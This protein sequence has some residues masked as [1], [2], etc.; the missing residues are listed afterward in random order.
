M[1]T[2]S[3]TLRQII[4]NAYAL[5]SEQSESSFS[6]KASPEKWSKKEIL[7]HLIDS[8]Y[9]NHQRFL[10]AETQGNL[11]FQGY[12]P[13]EWV[14]KNNYQNRELEDVLETW[15]LANLHLC[16][17]IAH[18]PNNLLKQ[19]TTAHNFHLIGMNR[20]EEGTPSSLSYLIWDYIF[21]LEHHLAQLLEEYKK[22]NNSFQN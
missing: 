16:H 14:R 12:H 18:L 22:I 1:N 5:L 15:K 8:A 7:G 2:Y 4:L 9:N 11:I 3:Q 20:P 6:Q 17:L 21:H 10:R 19:Q 13:D